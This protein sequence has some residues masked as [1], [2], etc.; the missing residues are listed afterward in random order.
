MRR[1]NI[2]L[3][4]DSP[5]IVAG[6]NVLLSGLRDMTVSLET[7]TVNDIDNGKIP[8][9]LLTDPL[10]LPPFRIREMRECSDKKITVVA[11]CQSVLPAEVMRAFDETVSIYDNVDTIEKII[12]RTITE[13]N[14]RDDTKVLSQREKDVVIGIVKGLS[15]KEIASEMGV[16]VNTVMTHRRNIA[17]K[18]Q[19]H[20]AAGLTIY[21]IVSKLVRLDEIKTQLPIK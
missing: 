5:V 16:S 17:Q 18:L 9:I 2:S 14:D 19:I 20:S 1:V 13:D 15:N 6:L 3:L 11:I 7:I 21:A 8:A 10:L 4:H 12:G